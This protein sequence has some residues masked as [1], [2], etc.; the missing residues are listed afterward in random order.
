MISLL[1]HQKDVLALSKNR[2]RVG[3]FLD[4]GLGWTAKL[5]SVLKRCTN[6]IIHLI[7]WFAKNQKL[8]IGAII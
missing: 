8:K 2:N 5:L 4:M 7:Y 6:L 1:P 3:Y